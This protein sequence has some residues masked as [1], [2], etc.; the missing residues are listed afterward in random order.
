MIGALPAV[1]AAGVSVAQVLREGGRGFTG[2]LRRRRAQAVL[3]TT[4]IA[5]TLVLLA[6]S[7]LLVKSFVPARRATRIDPEEALRSE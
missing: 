3:V 6:A 2:D 7:A 4:E 5:L 1:S